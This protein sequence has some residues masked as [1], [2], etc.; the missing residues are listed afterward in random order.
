M[1]LYFQILE[2]QYFKCQFTVFKDEFG[3][4]FELQKKSHSD[5]VSTYVDKEQVRRSLVV[6]NSCFFVLQH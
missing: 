2:F 5:K 6:Y 3:I 4:E 1:E